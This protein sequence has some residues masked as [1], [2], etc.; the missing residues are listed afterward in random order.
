MPPDDHPP[1]PA[2]LIFAIAGRQQ[3]KVYAL[4]LYRAGLAPWLLLS[5]GRFELRR[6]KQLDLPV[7]VDLVEAAKAVPAPLRH[8]FILFDGTGARVEWVRRRRFGT[9]NE[10]RALARWLEARPEIR[11][12]LIVSDRAHLRRV[13]MCCHALLPRQLQLS[14]V[15]V[16]AVGSGIID[17]PKAYALMEWLK[18]PPY[19]VLALIEMIRKS[20]GSFRRA[21]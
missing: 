15:A 21:R 18:T 20:S 2:G 16:P 3:R 13:R 6:A 14:F 4:E 11:S 8:F 9:W 12:L 10:I 19:L 7:A 17:R 5:F 1:A